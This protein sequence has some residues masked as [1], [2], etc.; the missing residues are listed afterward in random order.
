MSQET[1]ASEQ[2]Q[3]EEQLKQ[4]EQADLS[5]PFQQHHSLPFRP[6][7]MLASCGSGSTVLRTM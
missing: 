2:E 7:A 3:V 5:F 4:L 6:W 1:T